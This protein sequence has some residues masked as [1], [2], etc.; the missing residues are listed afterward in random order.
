MSVYKI[1]VFPGARLPEQYKNLIHSRW[2][3][4]F[5]HGNDY[6]KLSDSQTYYE[7]YTRYVD[8]ILG[9]R[10]CRVRLAVLDD[11][12]DVVLGFCVIRGDTVMKAFSTSGNILDYV[13]VHKDFRRLGIG[14]VLVKPENIDTTT[15]HTRTSLSIWGSKYKHWKFNPFA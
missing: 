9:R 15:H 5:R 10:D 6:I 14:T 7:A 12:H 2:K 3:R 13:H 4:S 11:D 1:I 8:I